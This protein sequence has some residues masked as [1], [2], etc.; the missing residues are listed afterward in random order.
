MKKIDL[1]AGVDGGE[2]AFD[3]LQISAAGLDSAA[4]STLLARCFRPIASM[5]RDG[6]GVGITVKEGRASIFGLEE[7]G[8]IATPSED[9]DGS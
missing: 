1:T 3:P 8:A 5:L 2:A 9:A 4:L 7:S 6:C